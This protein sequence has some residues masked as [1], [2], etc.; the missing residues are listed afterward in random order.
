[1]EVKG[2]AVKPTLEFVKSEFPDR[3]EEWFS[4]LSDE[5]KK[6]FEGMI[7]ASAWYPMKEAY[8]EPTKLVGEL[9][10]EDIYDAAFKLGIY[11]AKISLAGVY[12]VFVRIATP[13]FILSRGLKMFSSYFKPSNVKIDI[14]NKSLFHFY[15]HQFSEFDEIAIHRVSG[16]MHQ[17]LVIIK[18]TNIQLKVESFIENEQTVYKVI[19]SWD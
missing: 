9:F 1:M 8:L 15:I 3:Y 5:S 14:Q 19:C 13:R 11:S 17:A 4:K 16:W 2:T 7:S 6:I 12:K 10:F 18:R